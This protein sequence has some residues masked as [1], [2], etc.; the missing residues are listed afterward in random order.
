MTEELEKRLLAVIVA[1]L[2][3]LAWRAPSTADINEQHR[4]FDDIAAQL[5]RALA[6]DGWRVEP[7][8]AAGAP[9]VSS[10]RYGVMSFRYKPPRGP[11]A[12]YHGAVGKSVKEHITRSGF[13]IEPGPILRKAPHRKPHSTSQFIT[14]EGE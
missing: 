3:G 7:E 10:L 6:A 5:A 4:A 8:E 13:S 9:L 12:S 2:T 11:L 1:T 14:R